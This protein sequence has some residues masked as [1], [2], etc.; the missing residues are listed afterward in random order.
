MCDARALY[1]KYYIGHAEG[2][3]DCCLG[4]RET[5]P[6]HFPPIY[7][8]CTTC[9]STR[10]LGLCEWIIAPLNKYIMTFTGI[11]RHCLFFNFATQPPHVCVRVRDADGI[12]LEYWNTCALH[13]YCQN[14]Q[15]ACANW[16]GVGDQ[17][18]FEP[19]QDSFKN[20]ASVTGQIW[21][22]LILPNKIFNLFYFSATSHKFLSKFNIL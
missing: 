16:L 4:A 7:H 9:Y 8:I 12:V 2:E 15:I 5:I 11:A 1:K 10:T 18:W 14:N 13:G 17:F 21:A 19:H 6:C 3:S 20:F 22:N